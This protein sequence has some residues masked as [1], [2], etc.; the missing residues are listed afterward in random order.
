MTGPNQ[1]GVRVRAHSSTRL[2]IEG[3]HP[4]RILMTG[5]NDR[6]CVATLDLDAWRRRFINAGPRDTDDRSSFGLTCAY[7]DLTSEG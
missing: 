2:S 1:W 4:R 3:E 6:H 7:R 5:L